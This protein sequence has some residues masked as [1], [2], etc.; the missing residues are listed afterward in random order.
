MKKLLYIF[1]AVSII[2]SSCKKEDE[3]LSNNGNN[4]SSTWMKSYGNNAD[5]DWPCSVE[6]TSDGGF[7]LSGT[8]GND[9]SQGNIWIIKT[10]AQGNKSWDNILASGSGFAIQETNNDGYIIVNTGP[11][12]IKTDAQGNQQ[13]SQTL[14]NGNHNDEYTVQQTS[15]NGYI[16]FGEQEGITGTVASLIKTD[17][18]G[19]QIFNRIF[20][21]LPGENFGSSAIQTTDG[22]YLL[23]GTNTSGACDPWVIKTDSQGDTVWIRIF[24]GFGDD[25]G[26][27]VQQTSNN[28][29]IL[30]YNTSDNKIQLLKLNSIGDSIWSKTFNGLGSAG[31]SDVSDKNKIILQTQD[32]GYIICGYTYSDPYDIKGLVIKIDEL[33]NQIWQRVYNNF[34]TISID[35]TSDGGYII[36][37]ATELGGTVLIKTDSQGNY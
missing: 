33:G 37:G 7:V 35:E 23:C 19:N 30:G 18:Q 16:I 11:N 6:Q 15:D 13:W 3:E 20:G 2:F 29:Y 8:I 1:L 32:E 4:T 21:E 12:L 9:V 5:D 25:F 27:S 34:S 22:G 36:A 17:S 26:K 28:D 31:F 10:D 14:G 24:S